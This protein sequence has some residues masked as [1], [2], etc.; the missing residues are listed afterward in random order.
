MY[1]HSPS[2]S[3]RWSSSIRKHCMKASRMAG[4]QAAGGSIGGFLLRISTLASALFMPGKGSDEQ[5]EK[6]S[7]R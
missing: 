4:G 7:H 5:R 1:F 3:G 6:I 2:K